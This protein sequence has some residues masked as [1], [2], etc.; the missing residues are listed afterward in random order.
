MVSNKD[1]VPTALEC[2]L[3]PTD[4]SANGDAAKLQTLITAAIQSGACPEGVYN[5]GGLIFIAKGSLVSQ[6]IPQE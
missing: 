6:Y 2:K 3:G 1:S 5:V 4:E